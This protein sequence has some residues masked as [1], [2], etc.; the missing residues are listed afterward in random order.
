LGTASA[1]AN[2]FT[3]PITNFDSSFN[4][5]ATPIFGGSAAVIDGQLV[6]T[7][8]GVAERT[9]VM[10][11]ASRTGY[12][13]GQGS[14][15]ASSQLP[16]RTPSFGQVTRTAD[17]FSF[18]IMNVSSLWTWDATASAGSASVSTSGLVTVTG[19]SPSESATVTV[20]S[21]RN[22]YATGSANLTATALPPALSPARVPTF[23][24][25]IAFPGGFMVPITNYSALWEWSVTPSAGSATVASNG[26]IIVSGLDAGV[27][28]TVAVS[29][30]R[31]GFQSGSDTSPAGTSLQPAL[32]PTFGPIS[33][34]S[35]GFTIPITNYD[36]SYAWQFHAPLGGSV[37]FDPIA[38]TVSITGL[39]AFQPGMISVTTARSGYGDGSNTISGFAQRAGRTPV[40][41]S[42]VTRT[43]GGFTVGLQNFATQW[44]WTATV[45][46]NRA[47]APN[48]SAS[49]VSGRVV[50]TNLPAGVPATVTVL[51]NRTGFADASATSASYRSAG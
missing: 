31:S 34:I 23:G 11:T 37:S 38:R 47:L 3:V 16:A 4:W 6:V 40:F 43:V 39:A 41:A 22:L 19:L 9:T 8:L 15:S 32:N 14:I 36:S 17:G 44:T 12:L 20:T 25:P 24:S 42:S 1:S 5:A 48:A 21:S 51:T 7:G 50:V 35:G 30:A 10:V 18:S 33:Y 28:A 2:G 45:N 26:L 13:T 27:S 29:S 49:I 46:V